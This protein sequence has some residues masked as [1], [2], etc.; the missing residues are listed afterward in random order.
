MRTDSGSSAS[1]RS[2]PPNCFYR[3]SSIPFPCLFCLIFVDIAFLNNIAT[4]IVNTGPCAVLPGQVEKWRAAECGEK[5]P[6]LPSLP[7]AS[8]IAHR[9]LFSMFRL[10][11]SVYQVVSRDEHFEFNLQTARVSPKHTVE[12]VNHLFPMPFPLS[13]HF[14]LHAPN[15]IPYP[16]RT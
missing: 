7:R 2:N 3:S 13:N 1:L 8:S 16:N 15:P 6:G 11:S 14:K 12:S 9:D 10:V 4:S 5:N